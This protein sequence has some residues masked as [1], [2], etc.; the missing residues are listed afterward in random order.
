MS[1]KITYK[2]GKVEDLDGYESF[3]VNS[4]EGF[5]YFEGNELDTILI[6]SE[7]IAKIE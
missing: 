6:A 2:D 3:D 7:I 5:V 4:D 1:Y